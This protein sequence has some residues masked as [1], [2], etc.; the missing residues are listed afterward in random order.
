MSNLPVAEAFGHIDVVEMQPL[1]SPTSIF[2]YSASAP[3]EHVLG[4]RT[5]AIWIYVPAGA[6]LHVAAGTSAEV[7]ADHS[8]PLPGGFWPYA[9][10]PGSTVTCV[11][12]SDPFDFRIQEAQL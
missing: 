11:G 9:V 5:N 1:P 7:D 6:Q 8:L 10:T 4:S 12:V 3:V 2:K